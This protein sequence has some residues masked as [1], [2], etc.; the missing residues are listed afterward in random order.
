MNPRSSAVTL[1]KISLLILSLAG[2]VNAQSDREDYDD[3]DPWVGF[4]PRASPAD[5]APPSLAVPHC[6]R[7]PGS[8]RRF[9]VPS[10]RTGISGPDS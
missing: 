6:P 9:S 5:S 1:L 10:L 2:R 4:E 8:A 7:R 3:V